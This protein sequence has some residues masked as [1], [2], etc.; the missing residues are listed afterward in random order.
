MTRAEITEH[1]QSIRPQSSVADLAFYASRQMDRCDWRPF[2]KAAFERN[3]VS[4]DY[5][6]DMDIPEIY[7]A[8]DSWPGESIY[9]G[10]RMAMPDEVVNYRRGDGL[11]KAITLLDILRSRHLDATLEQHDSKLVVKATGRRYEFHTQ[12][13]IQ[14]PTHLL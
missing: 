3:P 11:E 7:A 13:N 6:I 5:F 9:E 8:L 12:K 1:L 10:P 4:V 14:I 2:L